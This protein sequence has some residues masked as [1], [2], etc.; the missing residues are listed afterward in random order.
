MAV[1]IKQQSILAAICALLL[2]PVEGSA[3]TRAIK[4][5]GFDEALAEI[6]RTLDEAN[7]LAKELTFAESANVAEQVLRHRIEKLPTVVSDFDN[8]LDQLARQFQTRQDANAE[9]LRQVLSLMR[10]N[11]PNWTTVT[12]AASYKKELGRIIEFENNVPLEFMAPEEEAFLKNVVSLMSAGNSIQALLRNLA[13]GNLLI[14]YGAHEDATPFVSYLESTGKALDRQMV[15]LGKMHSVVSQQRK[16]RR[17]AVDT[18]SRG[19]KYVIQSALGAA[20]RDFAY[21]I[22]DGAEK[23]DR[24]L[25]AYVETWAI[26]S[27]AAMQA[28]ALLAAMAP[29]HARRTITINRLR[30]QDIL[31]NLDGLSIDEQSR[32]DIRQEVERTLAGLRQDNG[33]VVA[34]CDY[35]Y[36]SFADE[37]KRI[38]NKVMS[39]PSIREGCRELGASVINGP[40]A[41]TNE[42]TFFEF[43]RR[44][45]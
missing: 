40:D 4:V 37:R 20:N 5:E 13:L 33:L 14:V 26:T 31:R 6:N 36:A 19:W 8:E 44:C 29:L 42:E 35:K 2:Y 18:I 17:E 22:I 30:L 10:A 7:A 25:R 3:G 43:K 12:D 27:S 38:V 11:T 41:F 23:A 24:G 1:D 28:T 9:W 15:V 16:Q 32:T 21:S 34:A 39:R 45:W